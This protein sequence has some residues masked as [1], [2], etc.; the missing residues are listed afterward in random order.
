M[1]TL[2]KPIAI[3]FYINQSGYEEKSKLEYYLKR[4][5]A[6]G[7]KHFQENQAEN[8]LGAGPLITL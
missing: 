3:I 6:A 1:L 4:E 7:W 8:H 5:N 2:R